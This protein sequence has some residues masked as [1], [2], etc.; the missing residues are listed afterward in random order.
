MAGAAQSV[1]GGTAV[2]F[3]GLGATITALATIVFILLS[4]F[5]EGV[6]VVVLAV[7][8][9][10]ILFTRIRRYYQRAGHALGRDTIPG[11]PQSQA[12]SS[13]SCRSAG[14]PG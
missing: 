1:N 14:Y 5:T 12:R 10:I 6:S 4:K 8:A 2:A 3:N 11:P 13:S 7:P 9:L